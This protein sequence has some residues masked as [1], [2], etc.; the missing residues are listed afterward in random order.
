MIFQ[1]NGRYLESQNV[2]DTNGKAPSYNCP[3]LCIYFHYTESLIGT[4]LSLYCV[5]NI[6]ILNKVRIMQQ[7]NNRNQN[8]L[9]AKN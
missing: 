7:L 4:S 5:L 6:A 9:D 8:F 2:V 1:N 3:Y